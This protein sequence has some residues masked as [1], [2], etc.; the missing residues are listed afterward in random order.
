MGSKWGPMGF[1]TNL[2]PYGPN[3]S[4]NG[5]TATQNNSYFTFWGSLFDPFP[6]FPT[7]PADFSENVP[8]MG[9]GYFRDRI[10]VLK[11]PADSSRRNIKRSHGEPF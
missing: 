1:Y 7:G 2:D 11:I 10:S 9:P 6:I 8:K 5:P 4:P 3:P